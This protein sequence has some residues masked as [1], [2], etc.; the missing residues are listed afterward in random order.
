MCFL[1]LGN[2]FPV[3][4]DKDIYIV[5]DTRQGDSCED[6]FVSYYSEFI[7]IA[8][9]IYKKSIFAVLKSLFKNELEAEVFHTYNIESSKRR[10]NGV[11]NS[12]YHSYRSVGVFKIPKGTLYY[13]S[14]I[15]LATFK[16]V[17]LGNSIEL[18]LK[19]LEQ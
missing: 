3:R 9:D 4:A 13:K 10:A 12:N 1:K 19:V 15:E 14:G 11:L 17:Y 6:S 18:F 2:R 7:Y 16:I 8:N 5:K